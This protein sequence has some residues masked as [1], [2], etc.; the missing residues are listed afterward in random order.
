VTI[1]NHGVDRQFLRAKDV[2][3]LR[4]RRRASGAEGWWARPLRI[5]LARQQDPH[6]PVFDWVSARR[7]KR[8]FARQHLLR[9]LRSV[10]FNYYGTDFTT[11][12]LIERMD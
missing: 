5:P 10:T 7:P 12:G 2:S 3:H 4:T 8:R 6:G 1:S 11:I 9:A